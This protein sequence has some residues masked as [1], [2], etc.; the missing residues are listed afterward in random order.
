MWTWVFTKRSRHSSYIKIPKEIL[1]E[2][3]E[4]VPGSFYVVV[5]TSKDDLQTLLEAARKLQ[6]KKGGG[7]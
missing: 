6:R 4:E 7:R 2:I 3:N 5:F 1:E